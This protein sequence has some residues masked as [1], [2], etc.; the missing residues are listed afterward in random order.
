VCGGGGG[1]GGGISLSLFEDA[2]H[3]LNLDLF[4]CFDRF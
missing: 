1:G 4:L 3:L 2:P